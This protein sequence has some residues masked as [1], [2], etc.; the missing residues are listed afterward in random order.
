MSLGIWITWGANK[1]WMRSRVFLHKM[2]H[3][4]QFLGPRR[5]KVAENGVKMG[6]LYLFVF[7]YAFEIA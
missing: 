4:Q 6:W 1:H 3:F 2:A 7:F 5:A